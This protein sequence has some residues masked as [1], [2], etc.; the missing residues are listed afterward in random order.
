MCLQIQPGESL[1]V[2]WSQLSHSPRLLGHIGLDHALVLCWDDMI[3]VR[4]GY[5]R[6]SL[7]L[8]LL[9]LSHQVP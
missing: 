2:G 7:D 4:G 5:E 9:L 1:V 3:E 8:A 6:V